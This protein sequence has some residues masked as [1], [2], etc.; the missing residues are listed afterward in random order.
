MLKRKPIF[1]KFTQFFKQELNYLKNSNNV[2][3][4]I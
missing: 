3:L 2:V 1:S 4:D